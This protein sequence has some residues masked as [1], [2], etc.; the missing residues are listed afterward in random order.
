MIPVIAQ[1]RLEEITSLLPAVSSPALIKH[2]ADEVDRLTAKLIAANDEQTRGAI[3]AL[4]TLINLPVSLQQER[5]WITAELT[6][7][8]ASA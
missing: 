6:A 2:L 5:D 1:A 4:S 3:L 7:Q 8:A